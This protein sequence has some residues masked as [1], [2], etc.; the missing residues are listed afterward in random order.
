M[1]SVPILCGLA[2]PICAARRDAIAKAVAHCSRPA[3]SDKWLC[4]GAAGQ[5]LTH[6]TVPAIPTSAALL[7]AL[8]VCM[9]V[10]GLH[11]QAN[12]SAVVSGAGGAGQGELLKL[13]AWPRCLL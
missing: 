3:E 12:D 1:N 13:F 2:S 7:W 11:L 10:C 6:G 9:S 8:C 4:T 5:A